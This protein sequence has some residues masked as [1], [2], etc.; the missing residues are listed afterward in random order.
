[1]KKAVKS[2][3]AVAIAVCVI[4]GLSM[5]NRSEYVNAQN[6]VKPSLTIENTTPL[7]LKNVKVQ[8]NKKETIE[9][10][11]IGKNESVNVPLQED[12]DPIVLTKIQGETSIAGNF[13]SS[14]SG[15][16]KGGTNIQV[17]L[18]EDMNMYVTS[19]VE[20]E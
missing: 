15:W 11:T 17:C 14:V 6:E 5:Y 16:V 1:M 20:T 19:N 8:L 13:A 2:I 9:L 3:I 10:G 18:D 7:E 4:I 12:A